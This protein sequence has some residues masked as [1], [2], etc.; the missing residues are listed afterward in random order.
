MCKYFELTLQKKESKITTIP[1]IVKIFNFI[2]G[3]DNKKLKPQQS[4]TPTK[5]IYIMTCSNSKW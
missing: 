1:N 4:L 2:G 5:L 3:K